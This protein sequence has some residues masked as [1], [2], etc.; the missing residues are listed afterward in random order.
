LMIYARF[1]SAFSV[2]IVP[3]TFFRRT[4]EEGTAD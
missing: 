1:L 4:H 2:L 3:V